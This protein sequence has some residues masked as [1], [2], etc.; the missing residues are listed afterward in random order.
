MTKP[1]VKAAFFWTDTTGIWAQVLAAMLFMY[2]L[3]ITLRADWRVAVFGAL[4]YGIST[5]NIDLLEAG[6]STKMA[7]MAI[8][9]GLLA[10]TIMLLNGRLLV[11]AGLLALFTAMQIYVN[12]VQIT[13]YTLLIAGIYVLVQLVESVR[14]KTLLNWGKQVVIMGLA[15]AIGFACNLSKLWP[16]YEYSQ[17]TIRGRS[18]LKASADKGDG[19]SKDYLFGWS[20]GVCESMTLLVPHFAGGGASETFGD[21]KLLKA[22]SRQMPP[23]TTKAQMQSQIAALFY[24]GDQPFVGTAIYFGAIVCFLFFL[25]A[26][27]VP[28]AVKWW[29]LLSGIFM[30]T[31]A[32]GSISFSTIYCT[33]I[34]QCSASSAPCPWRLGPHNCV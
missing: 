16:T 12:H 26:F 15:L 7:A 32:W 6:H 10:A 11:G 8:A 24:N 30:V 1:L 5:Y 22:V 33:T 3:I 21:T 23:N 25:G 4:A 9:P 14:H 20:Y 19:L 13:Y 34:C 18:E 2:L 27:L 17:E 28:G 29:L 31:L